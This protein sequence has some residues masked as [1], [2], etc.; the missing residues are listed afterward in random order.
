MTR[1]T[2]IH[3]QYGDVESILNVGMTSNN[4]IYVGVRVYRNGDVI[5]V[6]DITLTQAE[7]NQI[8]DNLEE[9]AQKLFICPEC[10]DI[11]TDDDILESLTNGGFGMCMCK[12][13]NGSRI[14]VDYDD[15]DPKLDPPITPDEIRLIESL[16]AL[17]GTD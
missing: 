2:Q 7:W 17:T 1:N 15:Y 10:G 6:G 5:E 16:R 14:F 13:G 11:V 4:G 12:F 9:P 8:N 3:K